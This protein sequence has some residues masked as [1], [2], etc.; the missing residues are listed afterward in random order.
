MTMKSTPPTSSMARLRPDPGGAGAL[1]R[2]F[3]VAHAQEMFWHWFLGCDLLHVSQKNC[4]E[5]FGATREEKAYVGPLIVFLAIMFLGQIPGWIAPRSEWWVIAKP[6]YWVIPLQTVIGTVLLARY[7]RIYQ[8]RFPS[9]CGIWFATF[10]GALALIL[11]IAPQ[12]WLGFAPRLIGFEPHYFGGPDT[13]MY[14]FNL[15]VRFIRLVIIVPL[16]EEIFWRGFL[17][18]YFVD[19]D[20][21]SVPMGAFS[22]TSFWIVVGGFCLEHSFADWPA[23]L[24]TGA[25]FNL[26]AYRTR[27]LSACVLTHAVTNLILGIWVMRTGQWGF[28]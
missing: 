16:I 5:M 27:S 4:F 14:W 19:D 18:R 23:A 26:V 2:E 6:G 15:V 17:L 7:W 8:M 28:W 21:T 9:W 13:W 12:Q 10:I 11:W 22:W 1:R 3:G 25:L 20:F 24:L